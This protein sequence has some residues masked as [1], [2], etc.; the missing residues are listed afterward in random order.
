MYYISIDLGTT[1]IKVC[2]YD[3]EL[4]TLATKSKN[5]EY[6]RQGNDIVEFDAEE[7]YQIVASKIEEC[8]I[9]AKLSK[10]YPITEII[11]TGQA[12]SL[13]CLNKDGKPIRPAISWL[14]NRSKKE[15][16]ELKK[17]FPPEICYPITGQPEIIPTWPITKILWLKHNEKELFDSVWKYILI[18][19]YIIY[20]LTNQFAGEYS[21]YNFSHFF[22]IK[23]KCFWKEELDYVGVSIEQLT[24]L[25]E[26]QT[27][28]GSLTQEASEITGMDINTKVNVGALDHFCGMIGTGNCV[29][30]MI[31]ESAGTVL[32][33]AT[34]VSNPDFNAKERI[35]L[36][37]GAFKDKYVYL[38]VCESG[39]ISME[40]FKNNFLKDISYDE[41]NKQLETKDLSN[42][43]LFMPYIAGTNA[44]E[45][46]INA[47]GMFYGINA[48]QDRYDFALAVMEGVSYLLKKNVDLICK[49]TGKPKTIISSG[50]G[51]K[52][53]IWCQ[54]KADITGCEIAIP[55]NEEACCLGAAII[56]AVDSKAYSNFDE[57]INKCVK[58]KKVYYPKDKELLCDKYKL[59]IDIYN[60]IEHLFK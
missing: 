46:N 50:G 34:S 27:I 26:P 37:Y 60:S 7:Y 43:L 41:L 56:G 3:K 36:H 22:D 10:P 53:A 19:D 5:V 12:E 33:I 29:D 39:G 24:N 30:G 4:N 11:L 23:N 58:I 49:N 59:F 21:I 55:E 35:P 25:V 45:F 31:S 17:Q 15:C 8:C 1:N 44:P 14:D 38:P 2:C 47:K 54:L 32:S 16:E 40:W 9:D 6:N 18:K 51:A 28:V 20:R 57:A 48:S 42:S 13:V 52:S